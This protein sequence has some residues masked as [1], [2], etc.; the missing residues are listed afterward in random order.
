MTVNPSRPLIPGLCLASAT[1]TLLFLL[2]G[3][4][5]LEFYVVASVF[6]AIA[7]LTG[8]HWATLSRRRRQLIELEASWGKVVM[9]RERDFDVYL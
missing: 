4:Y 1:L 2:L 3:T 6:A 5:A 9:D 8:R 7:L